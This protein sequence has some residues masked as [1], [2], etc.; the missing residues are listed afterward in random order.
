M[1]KQQTPLQ[2]FWYY[3]K[4]FKVQFFIVIMIIIATTY[5]Q[6]K[7]PI[8][9]GQA[10]NKLGAYIQTYYQSNGAIND[11]TAFFEALWLFTLF[12]I[13]MSTG[14]LIQML[15]FVGISGKS[16][17]RMRINLFEKL[18]KLAIRFF[19]SHNDG[20]ILIRFTSDI[21]NISNTL[22]QAVA[23][24]IANIALM[25]GV[26][27][28]MFRQNVPLSWVTLSAS[29]FAILIA[30]FIIKSASRHINQQQEELG[31]L[32]GYIDEKISGQKIII[33]YGL[34][35]DT[36]QHFQTYNENVKKA[37]FK[38]QAFSGLLFPTMQGISIV[39]MAIV[40]FFGGIFV[41][42]GS[43]PKEQGLA[44]LVAFVLYAQQFYQPLTQISSQ[45]NMLQLAFTGAR[46][47]AAIYTEENEKQNPQAKKI[48]TITGHVKLEHV[49][50][51]YNPNKQILSDINMTVT[52]GK[53]IALVGPTGSGK[54][55]IMNLLN[56]FYDVSSGRILIDNIDIRDIDLA[57]LRKNIGIVLQ[58]SVLFTGTIRDN[59]TFG[60]HDATDEEVFTAA[61]MA[62][63]HEFILSLDN[64]YETLVNDDN[65][66]F[67][68]GQKQLISIAR[69]VITNPSLLILDEAT[70]N[71]DTVTESRIQKAME[72][73]MHGRTSFVI[74]HRLKTILNA[75]HIVVLKEGKI[76]EQ[77]THQSLLKDNGFYAELYNNQF[78]FE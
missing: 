66:I 58:D 35:E 50:F 42:N 71:V 60:K 41:L 46:R 13:F 52:P 31:H 72:N 70:S 25:I 22:N 15:M 6:V 11:S 57:T 63:I 76:I 28:M 36:I 45:Y 73:V 26:I 53:M 16:T 62:N 1:K 40:I 51:A 24:V 10:I 4:A 14:M 56:R 49:D 20:E 65:N 2:F 74:A 37:S 38:G 54:T 33:T 43:I 64:G 59:I 75:D 19:D 27:I 55:T 77:G 17:N 32:N 8:F 18:E 12:V 78:V 44:I 23:Q 67:S 47:V 21:D 68:V 5:L 29:P 69:T 34:E 3:L 9:M 30:A 48:D 7:S 39:T 61:K